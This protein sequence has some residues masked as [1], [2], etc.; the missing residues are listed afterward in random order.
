MSQEIKNKVE[1]TPQYYYITLSQLEVDS[2]F[3]IGLLQYIQLVNTAIE[4]VLRIVLSSWI[5]SENKH[6]IN[7]ILDSNPIVISTNKNNFIKKYL[8]N[9]I[10]FLSKDIINILRL[11]P[12]YKQE[13]FLDILKDTYS[14]SI[15]WNRFIDYLNALIQKR[16]YLIHYSKNKE[17]QIDNRLVINIIC[18]FLLPS[19][20]PQFFQFLKS[21]TK[22]IIPLD[23]EY[24]KDI[25]VNEIF[26]LIFGSETHRGINDRKKELR[27]QL[28]SSTKKGHL[29]KFQ[30]KKKQQVKENWIAFR[31]VF[32]IEKDLK[33]RYLNFK[34]FYTFIGKNQVELIQLL[35]EKYKIP[36]DRLTLEDYEQIYNFCL[37][38]RRIIDSHLE[39]IKNDISDKSLISKT[40]DRFKDIYQDYYH[41]KYGVQGF[42][43]RHLPKIRNQN[44]HNNLIIAF[45]RDYV[46]NEQHLVNEYKNRFTSEICTKLDLIDEEHYTFLESIA[47]IYKALY[48]F[49][50]NTVNEFYT[51]LL[52]ICKNQKYYKIENP[53][54]LRKKVRHWTPEKRIEYLEVGNYK[55]IDRRNNVKVII[56]KFY[57]DIQF[58][59][60]YLV[61]NS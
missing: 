17:Q 46:L 31:D 22:N 28:G 9:N 11:V 15:R 1:T 53:E 60:K 32:Y 3:R 30:R 16:H 47:I 5:K 12:K 54:K 33:L 21:S 39:F 14:I 44:Q 41:N 20:T 19:I 27:K 57:Q 24:S 42:L 36:K 48:E 43:W 50:K 29:S 59:R 13:I 2:K 26:E 38:I 18:Q 10:D 4:N 55:I 6:L 25:T 7:H 58:V 56:S 52:S 23:K 40:N 34:R 49:N 8:K 35:F 61:K 51:K 37:D 45:T